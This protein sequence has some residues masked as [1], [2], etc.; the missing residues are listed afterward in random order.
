MKDK[1]LDIDAILSHAT[2]ECFFPCTVKFALNSLI[3][4]APPVIS[5]SRRPWFRSP[6]SP[7]PS[8]IHFFV[9]KVVLPRQG[10]EQLSGAMRKSTVRA[11]SGRIRLRTQAAGTPGRID[12]VMNAQ[13]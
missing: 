2:T 8:S 11:A 12:K 13:E 7:A 10:I 6:S 5:A 4:P 9:R 1:R 3:T